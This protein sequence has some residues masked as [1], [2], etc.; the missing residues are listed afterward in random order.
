MKTLIG[1]IRMGL[2]LVGIVS[3]VFTITGRVFNPCNPVP[4]NSLTAVIWE[5]V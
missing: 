2:Q 3:I 1:G 5:K 4:V